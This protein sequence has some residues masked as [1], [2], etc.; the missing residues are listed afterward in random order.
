MQ[1]Y[2]G[3]DQPGDGDRHICEA[4][5]LD[6]A[7]QELDKGTCRPEQE[8]IEGSL[9]EIFLH[10]PKMPEEEA[11][12]AVSQQP[13]AIEKEKLPDHP[14]VQVHKAIDNDTYQAQVHGVQ[15]DDV[16]DPHDEIGSILQARFHGNA[17][18]PDV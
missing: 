1:V 11:I 3:K 10:L 5:I 8:L 13:E 2:V 17:D 16:E 9:D 7:P 15:G 18:Q 12:Q 6:F 4:N 14:A